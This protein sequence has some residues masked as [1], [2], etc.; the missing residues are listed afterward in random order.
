ME[1]EFIAHHIKEDFF[2]LDHLTTSMQPRKYSE[3]HSKH[4]TQHSKTPLEVLDACKTRLR[5]ARGLV[6]DRF[7]GVCKEGRNQNPS[8][9]LL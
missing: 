2:R 4:S 5:S 9:I 8:R 3:D 1:H 7:M 6:R